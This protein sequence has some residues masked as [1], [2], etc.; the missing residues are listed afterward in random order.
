MK[1]ETNSKHKTISWEEASAQDGIYQCIEHDKPSI[2]IVSNSG[3]VVIGGNGTNP[4][5]YNLS[6]LEHSIWK[7]FRWYPVQSATF[8]NR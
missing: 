3:L 2:L 6:K 8:Y 4:T 1:I 5:I 7:T